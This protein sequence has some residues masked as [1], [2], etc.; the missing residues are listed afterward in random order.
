V[1]SRLHAALALLV[2]LALVAATGSFVASEHV[3]GT[4]SPSASAS[5]AFADDDRGHGA[6][7]VVPQP[8]LVGLFFGLAVVA[9][10]VASPSRADVSE[11]RHARAPPSR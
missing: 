4:T 8:L 9:L 5:F 3:L 1:R 11:P 6:A 7:T 2:A 10:V